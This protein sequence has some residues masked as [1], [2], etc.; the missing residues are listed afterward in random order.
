MQLSFNFQDRRRYDDRRRFDDRGPPPPGYGPPDDFRGGPPPYGDGPGPYFDGPYGGGGGGGGP[1]PYGPY[2]GG[3]PPPGRRGSGG[4][5]GGRRPRGRGEGPPGVSLLVRNVSNDITTTDLTSAFGRIGDVRDVYIPRDFH[6][7][8]PKGFAFVEYATHDQ[9][10]EAREEM[11]R[12]VMKGRELE[13]VFAQEKRKTPDQ[14]RGRV[15][16]GAGDR[17]GRG[18]GDRDRDRGDRDRGGGG[19]GDFER[20]SSFERH[21]RRE[22]MGGSP[23]R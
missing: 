5:G 22:R 13:V 19:G 7:Q 6:S 15:F 4:G 16:S 1:G 17:R 21:K 10:S 2:G 23:P 14:M 11:N 18:G 8:Q 9:A 3:G 12:F 20:S